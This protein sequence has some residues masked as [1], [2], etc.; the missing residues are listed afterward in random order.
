M[1]NNSSHLQGRV[2]TLFDIIRFGTD[3]TVCRS[4]ST[5]LV[6]TV[7]LLLDFTKSIPPDRS[8]VARYQKL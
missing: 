5:E 1:N 4:G 3:G 8:S 7:G 6:C 2:I